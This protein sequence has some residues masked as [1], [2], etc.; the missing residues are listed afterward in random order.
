VFTVEIQT[1]PA[2][3]NFSYG[4]TGYCG[5]VGNINPITGTIGT[6]SVVSSTG[7]NILSFNSGTGLINVSASG[8]DVYML[9]NALTIAGC[10]TDTKRNTVTIIGVP[11]MPTGTSPASVCVGGTVPVLAASGTGL[12]WYTAATGGTG[13]G[14]APVV[15]TGSA[16]TVTG[17]VSQT[18]NGCEGG[19]LMLR[20]V[21]NANPTVGITGVATICSGTGTSLTATGANTYN[22][23]P[24][25]LS[26]TNQTFTPSVTQSFTVTG[27]DGNGC[28]GTATQTITVNNLPIIGISG[29]LNICSGTGTSLTAMGANTYNWM[30]GNLSGT[31]QTFTPSVTQ[32]LTVTGTDA[33][34]CSARAMVTVTVSST[35]SVRIERVDN[36][37]N[38]SEVC[39]GVGVNYV[40]KA[41]PSQSGATYQWQVDN[42]NQG[43][44]TINNTLTTNML[45]VGSH[46]ISVIMYPSETCGGTT[47]VNGGGVSLTVSAPAA[48][49]IFNYGQSTICSNIGALILNSANSQNIGGSNNNTSWTILPGNNTITIG[50]NGALSIE[51]N[52]SG[53]YTVTGRN[54][55]GS[56]AEKLYEQVLYVNTQPMYPIGLA[57]REI[58]YCSDGNNPSLLNNNITLGSF[59][60]ITSGLRVEPDGIIDLANTTARGAVEVRYVYSVAGCTTLNTIIGTTINDAVV[61]QNISYDGPVS[62]GVTTL[63]LGGEKEAIFNGSNG[64]EFISSSAD[65]LI[66]AETGKLNLSGSKTGTYTITYSVA[67][68]GACNPASKETKV[69]LIAPSGVS[70]TTPGIGLEGVCEQTNVTIELSTSN[71]VNGWEWKRQNEGEWQMT[72]LSGEANSSSSTNNRFRSGAL[73]E[74]VLYRVSSGIS[75]CPQRVVS[76]VLT[77]NVSKSSLGG[78]VVVSDAAPD[79]GEAEICGIISSTEVGLSGER[80]NI[81]WEWK[82]NTD[83]VYKAIELDKHPSAN[84]TVLKT[85]EKFD[86][87]MTYSYRAKVKNGVCPAV[88]SLNEGKVRS[89]TQNKFIPN[90]LTPNSSDG[91]SIWK[92]E[93]YRLLAQAEVRI[94]NRYGVEVAYRTGTEIN[95][96]GWDGDNLPAG[97][98]YYIIDRNDFTKEKL[99][100]AITIVK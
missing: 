10:G 6:L 79:E 72:T 21:V 8:V 81:V 32:S 98:Y 93:E 47:Q 9:E 28:E 41:S 44:A 68:V 96:K 94:Y 27:V 62:D 19:R 51:S 18:I 56:C 58:A 83:T 70:I 40:A 5:N 33:N 84:S 13:S 100:G 71:D 73:T 23:M 91:N 59:Q 39:S 16:N 82:S 64:G 22:W 80:G 31:N 86:F 14:T 1:N 20:A 57:Y 52:A 65:L 29:N 77:V 4:L 55:S 75:A 61:V 42:T 74:G 78:T 26:G 53:F 45:S 69:S 3:A 7:G 54:T 90:A 49:P 97:T 37:V 60:A 48:Q 2:N 17:Y 66:D 38:G 92:I 34:N 95:S 12:Q 25:N 99:T 76:N 85:P 89:C 50:N 43:G 11:N 87:N 46:T 36:V 30:P 88:Y 15:S 35:P 24:G 63:C 67:G